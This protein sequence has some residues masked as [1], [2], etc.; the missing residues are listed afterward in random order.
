VDQSNIPSTLALQVTDLLLSSNVSDRQGACGEL[1]LVPRNSIQY[2]A[3]KFEEVIITG[4]TPAIHPLSFL[5]A[6]DTLLAK[7]G[8]LIISL[9]NQDDRRLRNLRRQCELRGYELVTAHDYVY[10]GVAT[11]TFRRT[12]KAPRWVV[13][14]AMTSDY[15]DI[16][17]LFEHVFEHPLSRDLWHWKYGSGRGDA[18][19]ALRGNHVVA[20]YGGIYRNV[21]I[22]GKP[23]RLAQIGDVMVHPNERG[24]LTRNGP[25]FLVGSSWLEIY[26]PKGFGFPTVRAMQV[27][28]KM[29]LYTEAGKMVEIQWSP[30]HAGPRMDSR[31]KPIHPNTPNAAQIVNHLWESM[32]DDLRANVVGVRSWDHFMHR[33]FQHPHNK[34]EAFLV[35][36]RWLAKPLGVFVVRITEGR[37]EL[38]DLVAPMKNVGIVLEQA[39]RIADKHAADTL[40]CWITDNCKAVF[41][42]HGGQERDLDLCVPA[43]SWTEH[44]YP[45]LFVGKWWLMSGDTDFR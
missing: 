10:C 15:A 21:L 4:L 22:E 27:A 37:C 3:A 39:R 38:L 25:F 29:G 32:A 26:G 43:S 36:S 42:K 24:V 33:Y 5:D 1:L 16:A 14:H 41:L 20:H 45:E 2:P 6:V 7:P 12:E 44:S 34:Y 35:Q 30:S 40:Y 9:L 8:T 23:D 19:L 11:Y 17:N 31:V 18:L 28:V 13:R